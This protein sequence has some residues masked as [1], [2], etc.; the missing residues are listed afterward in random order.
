[1]VPAAISCGE[2]GGGDVS[3]SSE[4]SESR[5][6]GTKTL[7]SDLDPLTEGTEKLSYSE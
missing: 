6:G 4:R 5:R 7:L 2:P 1:M 3:L